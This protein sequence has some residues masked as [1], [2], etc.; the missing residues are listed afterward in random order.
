V[1]FLDTRPFPVS[2]AVVRGW[3]N[4]VLKI[5]V[6]RGEWGTS[7]K[8]VITNHLSGKCK[9]P[10]LFLELL[11]TPLA[12]A[13]LGCG[14]ILLLLTMVGF[15]FAL[16]MPGSDYFAV[17]ILMAGLVPSFLLMWKGAAVGLVY[18]LDFEGKRLL[19]VEKGF[20]QGPETMVAKFSD[21]MS[22]EI[23]ESVEQHLFGTRQVYFISFLMRSMKKIV[24]SNLVENP[25]KDFMEQAE[26]LARLVNIPSKLSVRLRDKL[27]KAEADAKK[28]NRLW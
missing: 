6:S 15:F 16:N 13:I 18:I 7:R 21:L 19:S 11:V 24:V 17:G 20:F 27:A 12:D 23:D 1:L 28:A 2:E 8:L 9:V 4:L 14:I 26:L 25:D 5:L 3:F 22:V 10:K